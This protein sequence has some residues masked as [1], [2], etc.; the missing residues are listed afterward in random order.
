[1]LPDDHKID[2]KNNKM[3]MLACTIQFSLLLL[4]QINITIDSDTKL[5]NMRIF[6][7]FYDFFSDENLTLKT[8]NFL[9]IIIC[10]AF[11]N[12]YDLLK[13]VISIIN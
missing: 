9:N 4:Y 10:A 2:I 3:I 7:V 13:D 11:V 1:M 12:N 5:K 8:I 6:S